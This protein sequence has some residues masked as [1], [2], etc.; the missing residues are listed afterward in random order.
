MLNIHLSIVD[1]KKQTLYHFAC[2][3]AQSYL[4]IKYLLGKVTFLMCFNDY[5]IEKRCIV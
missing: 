4:T 2:Q 1:S 3:E 5:L